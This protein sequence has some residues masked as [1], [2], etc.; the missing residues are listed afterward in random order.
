[1]FYHASPY[2]FDEFDFSK[3]NH[4]R[5]PIIELDGSIT[6][7][8]KVFYFSSNKEL[9]QTLY[10]SEGYY[11]YEVEIEGN[12]GV[13]ACVKEVEKGRI[14]IINVYNINQNKDE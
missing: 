13:E 3:S 5:P 2:L 4:T 7:T 9:V 10:G 11:L 8:Q 14:K 12:V 6:P 1:M